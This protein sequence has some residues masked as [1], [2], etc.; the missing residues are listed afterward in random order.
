MADTQQLDRTY[1]FIMESFVARGQAPHFTEMVQAFAIP[2]EE[3]KR[4]LHELIATGLP[5]WLF[6]E[7][8]FITSFAP[9]NNLPTQYRITLD[10]E[11]KWFGQCG[12][13][14]LA[15]CWLFPGKAVHIDAPCLDCAAPLHVVVREGTI[16]QQDPPSICAYVDLPIREWYG[17]L[18]Y[19]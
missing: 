18:P 8:D 1:H 9:F 3:S 16:E 17:N 4:L 5:N 10:G 7:T 14:S 15:V 19:A 13:E 12:I 2:P 6:P 11:Q